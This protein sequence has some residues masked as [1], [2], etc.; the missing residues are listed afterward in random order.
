M[1]AKSAMSIVILLGGLCLVNSCSEENVTN[2][3][4][5]IY[6]TTLVTSNDTVYITD[7]IHQ[8]DTV[9]PTLE[10]R[11]LEFSAYLAAVDF[12]KQNYPERAG[13]RFSSLGVRCG[14]NTGQP[15]GRAG[16]EFT[17]NGNGTYT[18]VGYT[19]EHVFGAPG[20]VWGAAEGRATENTYYY[21]CRLEYV[22]SW[23]WKL[24]SID[25][26]ASGGYIRDTRHD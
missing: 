18:T 10:G 1:I 19:F 15:A 3:T 9:A 12:V 6:D 4:T 23:S 20:W 22:D 2:P 5:V 13:D 11:W 25:I 26:T 16:F 7:T 21:V 8:T 14:Y 17:D 24:D